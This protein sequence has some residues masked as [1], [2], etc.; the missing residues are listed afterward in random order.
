MDPNRGS[1]AKFE[2]DEDAKEAG[3]T[4]PLTEE[5]Y[6]QLGPMNRHERRKW[7]A[8]MRVSETKK[9]LEQAAKQRK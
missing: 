2:T 1:I 9:R 6:A 3:Y 7:A 5:Q 8:E 4:V